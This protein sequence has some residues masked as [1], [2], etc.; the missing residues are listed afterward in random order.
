MSSGSVL[1]DDT[2]DQK[3]LL[4]QLRDL[5][6]EEGCNFIYDH[7]AE[8]GDYASFG[9]LLKK[10]AQDVEHVDP[11]LSLKLAELL[12]F[13]GEKTRHGESHALGL[14]ARGNILRLLGSHQAAMEALDEAGREFREMADELGWARSR[15]SWVVAAT[16]LGHVE[17][18][19]E[20]AELA[21][22]TCLSLQENFWACVIEYNTGVIYTQLGRYDEAIALYRHLLDFLPTLQDLDET[23]I[24]HYV[25]MIKVNYARNLAF[26][27][28]FQ[29]AV[30]YQL[31]GRSGF[32]ALKETHAIAEVEVNL[33]DLGYVQGYY[34]SALSHYYQ[35][36]D[37]LQNNAIDDPRLLAHIHTHMATCLVKL[38][39]ARE[40]C[41]L[42]GEALGT[43]RELGVS[44]DTGEA[45]SEYAYAL[46]AARRLQEAVKALNEADLLFTEGGF[47]HHA[48]AA[49]LQRAELLVEMGEAEL[50][51]SA[52]NP[53]HEFFAHNVQ[54]DRLV[55]S[56]LVQAGAHILLAQQ[57]TD[58]REREHLFILASRISEQAGKVAGSN[59]LQEQF[60]QSQHLQGKIALLRGD[61]SRSTRYYM[62][63]IRQIEHMLTDLA[64]DLSP[65]FLHR[66]WQVY[67]DMIAL[68]L[69]SGYAEQAFHHLERGRSVVLRQYLAVASTAQETSAAQEQK[70]EAVEKSVTLLRLQRELEEWGEAYRT[71][72]MQLA[73]IEARSE[74]PLDR[75]TIQAELSRCE[76]HLSELSERV[77]ILKQQGSAVGAVPTE[78]ER[79]G[80]RIQKVARIEEIR[81]HVAA[82]QLVLTYFLEQEK[83]TIFALSAKE[84]KCY[85]IPG[86]TE[87]LERWLPI[88]HAHLQSEG[89][90]DAKRPPLRPIRS[91]LSKLYNLLIASV[92]KECGP[93]V[94]LL[95]IVP[96]G[97]LHNIP[98]HALYTG[99]QYLIE[100]YQINYLPATS[101]LTL[102]STTSTPSSSELKK[103]NRKA[104]QIFGY[105]GQQEILRALEEADTI[106]KLLQGDCYLQEQATIAR[107][108]QAA[109][110]APVIHLA[111]HGRSR[112]DAPNFSSII[113]ADGPLTAL[114]AFQLDLQSC[115]LMTLS[116][117]ETGLALSG[118]GDEQL[119]LGRAFLAAGVSSLVMSSWP[120]EDVAT[121]E[122]MQSFYRRLFMGES[123]VQALRSAQCTLLTQENTSYNHPYFWSAFRLVGDA[124][125]L[126]L[127]EK[128]KKTTKG[129]LVH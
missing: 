119:G 78:R 9:R 64:H 26:I 96:Y 89:W 126:D 91:L 17:Q 7:L 10:D 111:T 37:L 97:P 117:C 67:E 12:V 46:I 62:R 15:I 123:K 79:Q 8:L 86:A 82:D 73:R 11:F 122:M 128:R 84:L 3:L 36:R 30:R 2:M 51:L 20:Q 80:R 29:L 92:I 33:A 121:S 18:A 61:I 58:G 98:F 103:Q 83:L 109:A 74:T 5:S 71:Y 120:V 48:S 112:L 66:T 14:I 25:S 43:Y 27:G 81:H 90:H 40:A 104:P 55:R 6:L 63:A 59:N 54:H 28:E 108:M 68:W 45:L 76:E 65:S 34:G 87:Q 113:L 32:T 115:Q 39:R 99:A 114:D 23:V 129:I 124:G 24:Q 127:S 88:L 41:L 50:A 47:A 118:G 35:G 16:W 31:E 93:E 53:I 38:G 69:S 100:R 44:L 85:E 49:R 94:K 125:P 116:G 60:Y 52:V 1:G 19:L 42:A 13:F 102:F 56:Y 77:H 107:L 72:S 21:R 4:Q 101:M 70:A 105:S 75:E 106:A 110:G 95:T 22:R 57:A